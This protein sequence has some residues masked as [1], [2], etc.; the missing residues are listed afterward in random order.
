L[1]HPIIIAFLSIILSACGGGGSD[2]ATTTPVTT[3]LEGRWIYASAGHTTGSSCGL[4]AHGNNEQRT[5]FTF[6]GSNISGLNEQCLILS[7]NTGSFVQSNN[8]AGTFKVGNAYLTYGAD[9]YKT[10][11]VTSNTGTQ[12]S[13][14]AITGNVLKLAAASGSNDGSSADKRLS[15][16]GYFEQPQFIKQ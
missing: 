11:D 15:Y 3:D 7:G 1:K 2:S 12:Y 9:T 4:D 13:G 6:T 8:F 16:V 10:L 14:Y 5:T